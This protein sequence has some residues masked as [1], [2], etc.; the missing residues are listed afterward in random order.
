MYKSFQKLIQDK[1]IIKS[2][3]KKEINR[4][5]HLGLKKDYLS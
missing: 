2:R 3:L 4:K 5:R 1:Y